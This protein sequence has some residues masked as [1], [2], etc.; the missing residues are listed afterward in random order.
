MKERV[1]RTHA[2]MAPR[3]LGRSAEPLLGA[4]R[5]RRFAPSRGSALR[6]LGRAWEKEVHLSEIG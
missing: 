2:L 6:L 1:P 3:N 4:L 5:I